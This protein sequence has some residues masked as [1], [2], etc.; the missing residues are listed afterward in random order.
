M[1]IKSQMCEDDRSLIM[2]QQQEGI[3]QNS[4]SNGTDVEIDAFQFMMLVGRGI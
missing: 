4:Q 2:L 1:G 3:F